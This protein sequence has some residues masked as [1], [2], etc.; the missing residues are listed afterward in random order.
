MKKIFRTKGG[1]KSNFECIDSLSNYGIMW[2]KLVSFSFISVAKRGKKPAG[3]ELNV[4]I[5]LTLVYLYSIF[6]RN[7][8]WQRIHF[9]LIHKYVKRKFFEITL[10]Y[11]KHF[12]FFGVLLINF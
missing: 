12:L 4:R 6:D 2:V 10:K 7:T 3:E 9:H 5:Q 8:L 11:N 1:K